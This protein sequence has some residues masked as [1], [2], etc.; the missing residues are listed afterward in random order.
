MALVVVLV[1]YP[2]FL[3]V[4]DLFVGIAVSPGISYVN[5]F[6][7]KNCQKMHGKL[8]KISKFHL[9]KSYRGCYFSTRSRHNV[10]G[11]WKPT[12][13][14]WQI[15]CVNLNN[16][17]IWHHL[18]LF[19]ILR[20]IIW[21]VNGRYVVYGWIRVIGHVTRHFGLD[22]ALIGR[23]T[24]PWPRLTNGCLRGIDNGRCWSRVK[25]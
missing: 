8:I 3:Y 15:G 4:N 18:L 16:I 6:I 2:S 12:E 1:L 10:T 19:S 20:I 11:H 17:I 21:P 13:F 24:L 14:V 9:N 5:V 22:V 7:W 23:T 25:M